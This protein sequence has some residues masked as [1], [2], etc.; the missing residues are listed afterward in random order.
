MKSM[1]GL[2]HTTSV[3]TT[4]E[5][6][7]TFATTSVAGHKRS[8]SIA[9][10]EHQ[11]RAS[12][13]RATVPFQRAVSL[14]SA[15][16][17]ISASRIVRLNE[18]VGPSEYSQ[19][20]AIAA[21]PT[22]SCDPELELSHSTYGLH[23]QLV[24]NFASLGIKQ[25]YPWQKA[26]LKGPGLLTGEKNLVY[27]APTGGGKSLVA[28]VLML[29]RIL[30][31][32][33]T[34]A[35]LVLPYVALVQEKVRWLRSVVQGL[36]FASETAVDDDKRIWRRRADENTVRV[37]GFF[38]GGKVR[39]TWAD[40]DIGVCTLE[41]ANALVNTA[42]DDCSISK[43]RAVVLDELHM[44]DDDHR[45]YLLELVAA[46][47]LSLEQRV[48]IVGMSATLP[49]MDMMARWLDGHCYETRYRPV[50]IE[51]HLV[52]DGNIYPAGSTS[53]LI[54]TAAQLNSRSTQ[55]QAPMRPI[56]RIEPS[57]H[58]ELRDPVLN[59]VVTLAHETAVAGYG[60]LV[61]A[62]S[63]GMCESDARWISR[64]MP[65]PYELKAD[66]VDSRM[67]LLG[68][69]RS[70]PTGV[71]PVLEETVLYGVA[72][73]HVSRFGR[74]KLTIISDYTG[75]LDD[76]RER[77]HSGSLRFW[78][79]ISV[80]R[81][82]QSGCWPARR[83]VLHNCRMGREF[84]GPSM[85]RQMRGRAGRQGKASI[86]ETY[87]CCR[88]NDLEQVVDLMNAELPPVASCLNTENRRIQ[89]ALLEVI[90]IRLATSHESIV[91]YFSKSLLSYTHS[92]K[93]VNDCITSSLEEIES[94]GFVTSDS[95]SMF[96]A[97]QL[98]RAI[99]ASAIDPDDGVFVHSELSRALQAFV[100]DGEMHVLY[101]FTP[102]QE[103]GVMVNWQVFR[104]EMESLDESG[105]RV[106]RLLGIKPTTIL[107]LAQG[108]TL[109]ETTP[110]EKQVARVHRRFYLAL[111]LRD[112]CNE[113]PIHIVAR[114]YDVPRGMVQNLSQTCQGFAAGMIKFCEQ[115]SWGVMA[116]A[117]E[118]FSDRLVAGARADLLALAK[119][120]FIKSRTARV[121]WENGFRTVATIA[122]ADP[123][124]LFPILMQAQ[125][126]KIRLK[127]KDNDKYEEKLLV[128]AKVISDAASKIWILGSFV[129]AGDAGNA[130]TA[131]STV[132]VHTL[133]DAM[134]VPQPRVI[135][136]DRVYEEEKEE[137]ILSTTEDLWVSSADGRY[138]S[139]P[140]PIR[141]G[142]LNNMQ[143]F[144]VHKDIL[145][146]AEWFQ[147]AL[148]GNFREASEQFIDLPEEDPA[149]FHF[150]VAF[151]YEGCYEPIR[152]AA[153]VLEPE[154]DKGKGIEVDPEPGEAS[155]SSSSSSSNSSGSSGTSWR[156]RRRA[157]QTRHAEAE[158]AQEKHPGHHRPGCSCPRCLA[159]RDFSRCWQCGAQRSREGNPP[160]PMPYGRGAPRRG[161]HPPGVFPP[162]V[163]IPMPPQQSQ[164]ERITGEDLRTWFLAYELNLDVYICATRY[165]MDD[166][167]KAVMR[168]CVDMLETAGWDAAQPKMMHL[169]RKL[170]RSVPEVDDLLK[171]VL[172]R[173]GFLQPLLWKRAPVE[174]S[175]FLVSNPELAAAILR[176][177]VM[178]HSQPTADLPSMEHVHTTAYEDEWQ[179]L[180]R[181]PAR[182]RAYH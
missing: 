115:M 153:S 169:C 51:E 102:V 93:F 77:S 55:T 140:V 92:A 42:I 35:L 7:T 139:A 47:L 33:G 134:G 24:G 154:V 5:Q 167:R 94:M 64:A 123:T 56:R 132:T 36:R 129:M 157:R 120:P 49:N 122:N 176:E 125:P 146:Q 79:T 156:R 14:P 6:K 159:R 86:G 76:R 13:S 147:K 23:Q 126:N 85:L 118:H 28:D 80:R 149:I 98:G 30:E 144:Y 137:H 3:E 89:R 131:G 178:R 166:F 162:P 155:D 173:V 142:P 63:R 165:L 117:L 163:S 70:L 4:N 170:H 52:Y 72:F 27:C 119:I 172:A 37:I 61:F 88:E 60:A 145:V 18:R 81:D 66:V 175:E 100:M 127:G 12:A 71:D 116:A 20:R 121:F 177:T 95:L 99:V 128:K 135:V 10:E 108:A 29:K 25:I 40:F 91:D 112:L 65:Q 181:A 75:W 96:T 164:P 130:E 160:M 148:C 39:A 38:G 45:G 26:C 31:E 152:P 111:Q 143:T 133:A 174:T 109:R 54:K 15:P 182:T 110:E 151:L 150:L 8:L 11:F 104:N 84:V 179:N 74:L 90:S 43:L 103:F 48:Q 67:D 82:L 161:I 124:E 22:S 158:E 114:K 19:R 2:L 141:V 113:I 44:V 53:S 46:K 41:K 21:T 138:C 168:S 62:G 107:K 9:G 32:K 68:E 73:H 83:V 59:A 106:L 78:D 69:L 50:P 97:T 136:I 58:K 1:R 17:R 34:K 180:G 101:T 105:L 87:L 171:M 16:P 57:T